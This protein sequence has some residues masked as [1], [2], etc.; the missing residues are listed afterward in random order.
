[1]VIGDQLIYGGYFWMKARGLSDATSQSG[2]Y[3][4]GYVRYLPVDC[5]L[6]NGDLACWVTRGWHETKLSV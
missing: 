6:W 2:S 5:C 3:Y 1:M 4:V